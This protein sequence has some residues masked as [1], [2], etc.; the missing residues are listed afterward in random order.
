M[1]GSRPQGDSKGRNQPNLAQ[2]IS[3]FLSANTDPHP[4]EICYLLCLGLVE[5][6]LNRQ[7][8]L[9][10]Y[11]QTGPAVPVS[12]E[13]FT[14]SRVSGTGQDNERLTLRL[15]L[16]ATGSSSHWETCNWDNNN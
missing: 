14:Q 11:R 2:S 15:F 9:H 6:N 13:G 5:W 3:W 16:P 1:G 10:S 7:S 4:A 12:V 8:Q